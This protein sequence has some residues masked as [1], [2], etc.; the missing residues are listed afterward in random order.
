MAEEK[1]IRVWQ[2]KTSDLSG[3]TNAEQ[4]A[5]TDAP[6]KTDGDIGVWESGN[7]VDG[8]IPVADLVTTTG[9][10]GTTQGLTATGYGSW[11]GQVPRGAQNGSNTVFLLDYK[12]VN[13]HAILRLNGVD[14][15]PGVQGDPSSP[16]AL[17]ATPGGEFTITNH[18]LNVVNSPRAG[19]RFFINYFRAE[20]LAAVSTATL[21]VWTSFTAPDST[22]Y[23]IAYVKY[24]YT[25]GTLNNSV[26]G[27]LHALRLDSSALSSP[28]ASVAGFAGS[29][30]QV[31]LDGSL[32]ANAINAINIYD[33]YI[34]L[35]LADA[36]VQEIRPVSWAFTSGSDTS[37]AMESWGA[38]TGYGSGTL[39][40]DSNGNVQMCTVAGTSGASA[41]IWAVSGITIDGGVTWT[42]QGDGT[43]QTS[44]TGKIAN[45]DLAYDVDSVPPTTFATFTRSHF[46]GLSTGGT[47]TLF[48]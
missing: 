8:N 24:T 38:S 32:P 22:P 42:Y 31:Y 30:V 33:C 15:Q 2:A 27:A 13:P 25:A 19:E 47:F 21:H 40:I 45:P 7:I 16:T 26:D 43:T 39:I 20:P 34:T 11:Y 18:T 29:Y 6:A 35:I 9:A 46:S 17:M 44:S 1:G 28:P 12:L 3:G 5:S 10:G 4:F 14:Q 41:P 36:S 37:G 48:F 23:S